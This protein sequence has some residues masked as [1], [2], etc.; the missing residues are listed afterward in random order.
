MQPKGTMECVAQQ[1]P[2]LA[3][4]DAHARRR[5]IS[6]ARLRFRFCLDAIETAHARA[7]AVSL[8]KP[9]CLSFDQLLLDVRIS[10]RLQQ[11]NLPNAEI[12]VL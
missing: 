12:A 11:L 2:G 9:A 7:F 3:L 10:Q 6:Q 1:W 8:Q 5:S 4:Q